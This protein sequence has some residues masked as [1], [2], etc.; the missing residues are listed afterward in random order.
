MGEGKLVR[1]R[2][3]EILRS[4]GLQP[5]VY[6]ASGEEYRIQLRDKLLEE[7]EEFIASDN[8]PEEFA[9]IL[10]VLCALAEQIGISHR[11]L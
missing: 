8:D 11:Q 7:V 3:P 6:T 2:I 1:G 4:K 10:E 5:V 9:D